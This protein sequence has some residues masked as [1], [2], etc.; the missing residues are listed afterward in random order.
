MKCRFRR[1]R[2]PVRCLGAAAI[3]RDLQEGLIAWLHRHSNPARALGTDGRL[4]S[5][6]FD[7]SSS[8]RG[9]RPFGRPP[10]QLRVSPNCLPAAQVPWWWQGRVDHRAFLGAAPAL[11]P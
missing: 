11:H 10:W 2:V 3:K 7:P 6:P 5:R 1:A 9:V 8:D 4:P